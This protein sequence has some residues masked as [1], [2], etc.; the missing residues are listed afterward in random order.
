MSQCWRSYRRGKIILYPPNNCPIL[1]P[2]SDLFPTG[3]I[4]ETTRTI[5]LLF[6]QSE[7]DTAK[8]FRKL[9]RHQN[10]DTKMIKCGKLRA[11]DRQID[12][13]KFWRDRIVILKQVFDESTPKTWLQ[14]WY[15][16]RNSFE[17]YPVL[18]AAA[19]LMLT[20]FFGLIQCI[21]GA[22]Q[23]FKAYHPSPI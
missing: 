18:L 20:A 14:W 22:L 15:D 6:P 9:Q 5:R 21:E 12:T 13:F 4:E 1:K 8:W 19:A 17:R 23:V 11:E 10:L 7:S 3:F 2:S 16:R